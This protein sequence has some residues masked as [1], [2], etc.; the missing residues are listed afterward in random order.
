M[1]NM[2]WVENWVAL[3]AVGTKFSV[4]KQFPHPQTSQSFNPK[5]EKYSI[6][7]FYTCISVKIKGKQ[8]L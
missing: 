6:V 3:Y 8:F 4:F 7:N 5:H 1:I 2:F